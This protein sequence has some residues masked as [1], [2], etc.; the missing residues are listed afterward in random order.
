VDRV[1]TRAVVNRDIALRGEHDDN[2]R[3][4]GDGGSIQGSNNRVTGENGSVVDG[5]DEGANVF[6]T[7]VANTSGRGTGDNAGD[8][9][10]LANVARAD[11][12]TEGGVITFDKL[13]DSI[14]AIEGVIG[15]FEVKRREQRP[16]R[17]NITIEGQVAEGKNIRRSVVMEVIHT[18]IEARVSGGL[19]DGA[20]QI[21]VIQDFESPGVPEKNPKARIGDDTSVSSSRRSYVNTTAE[22]A[23]FGQIWEVTATHLMGTGNARTARDK[24]VEA[25]VMVKSIRPESRAKSGAGEHSTECVTNG[26]MGT[27]TRPILMG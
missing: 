20:G 17:G 2:R 4:V 16:I 12:K 22:C 23:Q 5:D 27:L 18:F 25:H 11:F 9:P 13:S 3:V 1:V 8:I 14:Q 10:A 6:A 19:D 21:I 7:H 15:D 26:L 24:I